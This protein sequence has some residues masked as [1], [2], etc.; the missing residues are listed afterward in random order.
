[1]RPQIPW[2]FRILWCLVH[3]QTC[4]WINWQEGSHKQRRLVV[5]MCHIARV[6]SSA[7]FHS[8]IIKVVLFEGRLLHLL[9]TTLQLLRWLV[10][11]NRILVVAISQHVMIVMVVDLVKGVILIMYRGRRQVSTW[12]RFLVLHTLILW[13]GGGG[14]ECWW[15][16]CW[17]VC[18]KIL[19]ARDYKRIT[20]T[21]KEFLIWIKLAAKVSFRL[22]NFSVSPLPLSPFQHLC[23][24]SCRCHFLDKRLCC[25]VNYL[26]SLQTSRHIRTMEEHNPLYK[27]WTRGNCHLNL[28]C[29][30]IVLDYNLHCPTLQTKHPI[31]SHHSGCNVVVKETT[32]LIN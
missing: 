5:F 7:T 30:C 19:A 3:V 1:M 27:P 25:L 2:M 8:S 21:I 17:I 11:L 15:R 18:C 31:A 26:M 12:I 6:T 32:G 29:P 22:D 14:G 28:V 23:Y 10:V 20:R 24:P 4:V 13:R 9:L 16:G